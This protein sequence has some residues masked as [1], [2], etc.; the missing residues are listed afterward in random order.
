MKDKSIKVLMVEPHEI[1]RV[2]T[3]ATDLDSLQKAVSK[4]ADTQGLI[5]IIPLEPGVCLICNED[6]KLIGLE[7]NRRIGNDIIA[8]VFYVAGDSVSKLKSLTEAQ[9][10]KYTKL[11]YVPENYTQ[12]EVIACIY[13]D[14]LMSDKEE[15]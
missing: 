14:V 12:E 3:I 5:E 11:F 7:G 6:G 15:E 1:P 4:G 2:T 10:S 13:A 9:I 8:G